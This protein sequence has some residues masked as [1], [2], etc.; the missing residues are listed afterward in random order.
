MHLMTQQL[1][2]KSLGAHSGSA[3]RKKSEKADKKS[4]YLE[5]IT[6]EDNRLLAM[7]L[8]EF[9]A[10]LAIIEERLNVSAVVLGNVITL[11]GSNEQCL[12]ARDVLEYL[13]RRITKGEELNPGDI[14]G[15]IRHA[16]SVETTPFAETIGDTSSTKSSVKKWKTVK[17]R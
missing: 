8:G 11:T 6:F 16:L 1:R 14:D 17:L 5:T 15:A 3:R 7:L 13:F 4:K 10:N 12:L 2:S 9:D